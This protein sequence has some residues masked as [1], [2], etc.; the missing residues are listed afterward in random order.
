[1][2]INKN[3]VSKTYG[4]HR[5]GVVVD[6]LDKKV[7]TLLSTFFAQHQNMGSSE[8]ERKRA[9]LINDFSFF[10]GFFNEDF[11]REAYSD[12]SL[13]DP[14]SHFILHG[15]FED[16]WPNPLFE[17]DYYVEAHLKFCQNCS[18]ND[19]SGPLHFLECEV[20]TCPSPLLDLQPGPDPDGIRRGE[21]LAI[22]YGVL[23]GDNFATSAFDPIFVGKQLEVNFSSHDYFS[24][25]MFPSTVSAYAF[26]SASSTLF[27][28]NGDAN[29]LLNEK[30]IN[31]PLQ[32]ATFPRSILS[33][34]VLSEEI[35]ERLD[36]KIPLSDDFDIL[37]IAKVLNEDLDFKSITKS[38]KDSKTLLRTQNSA[39]IPK[40]SILIICLD[41]AKMVVASLAVLFANSNFGPDDYEILILDNA[42]LASDSE[43]LKENAPFARI[44][45]YEERV[46]FGEANNVLAELAS[47]DFLLF[48]NSDA[49]VTSSGVS[50]LMSELENDK[51]AVAVAPTLYF[52]NGLLQES[53]GAWF[54]DG[55]VVQFGK[56]MLSSPTIDISLLRP[57]RSAACLMVR[58]EAFERVG[59]FSYVF[60]PV[61]FE[62]TFL[63]AELAL[64]GKIR[65]IPEVRVVHLEGYTTNK[66]EHRANRELAISLN[67]QKFVERVK[68]LNLISPAIPPTRTNSTRSVR[69]TALLVSPFGLMVGGG[70]QYLLTLAAHLSDTHDIILSYAS[71]PSKYRLQ[72]VLFDLGIPQFEASLIDTSEALWLRPEILV[73]MG[74]SLLPNFPPIGQ[75]SVYH[76][77]FP[78]PDGDSGNRLRAS[79]AEQYQAVVVNSLFTAINAESSNKH[80]LNKVQVISPP[81]NAKLFSSNMVRTEQSGSAKFRIV[82]VGR[83][84]ENDHCK[85]QVEMVRAFSELAR[86]HPA[87]ELTLFGGV[88]VDSG[89]ISYLRKVNELVGSKRVSVR[90]NASRKSVLTE[91][92]SSDLYWHAAGLG[93]SDDEPWKMEHFGIAPIEACQLGVF[94]L[95]HDSGGL[96][97]NLKSLS[98]FCV[99]QEIDELVLKTKSLIASR[100]LPVSKSGVVEFGERF[101]VENF[102]ENW[103][104]LLGLQVER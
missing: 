63:C 35:I 75:Q 52:P 48:L 80:W 104:V 96:G 95:A 8:G 72:R 2:K 4:S 19:Q 54:N 100:E 1:M 32:S 84:F 49:F 56:G 5:R 88:A 44:V 37:A 73:S 97:Q 12:I 67:R 78:F 66:T 64:I 57:Y 27:G 36:Q 81:V 16:R 18:D 69:P 14:R 28:I 31:H 82:S 39:S 74:N 77:Q 79:W 3:L 101:S 55:S 10:E 26:L 60:E 90:P 24:L 53:G 41:N 89:S 98:E 102:N 51:G 6:R 59:G 30:H 29:F 11:Y 50:H 62:D 61:Y 71:V 76:C 43:F 46:S 83:F 85:N 92:Q 21:Y 13:E 15:Q 22:V 42:S 20:F 40:V 93:V 23:N 9:G 86:E 70:E 94:P 65:T 87:I 47:S 99:Y 7:K 103:N 38:A 91:L 17:T 25:S 34:F 58:R 45:R 68:D 33:W